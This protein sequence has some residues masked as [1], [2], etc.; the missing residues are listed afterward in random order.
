MGFQLAFAITVF[1]LARGSPTNFWPPVFLSA[2]AQ[3]AVARLQ[4]Q[5]ISCSMLLFALE[6]ALLFESRRTGKL[7]PLLW[8]PLLFVAWATLHITFVY[9]LFALALLLVAVA[10][11]RLCRRT[12]VT[13]FEGPMPA[14]PVPTLAAL[15]AASV[16]AGMFSPYSYHVYA[17]VTKNAASSAFDYGELHA[18]TSASRAITCCCW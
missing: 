18:S 17:A 5:P 4:P 11:E 12:E 10:I 2:G 6:L 13:W 9:G 7:G 8:L 1:L 16:A 3:Y 15:T 14:L